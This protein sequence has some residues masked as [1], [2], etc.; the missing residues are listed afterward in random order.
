LRIHWVNQVLK[1]LE[2]LWIS[3]LKTRGFNFEKNNRG[4]INGSKAG[5]TITLTKQ[6]TGDFNCVASSVEERIAVRS[7]IYTKTPM[8]ARPPAVK[9]RLS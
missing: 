6:T 2:Q 3:K 1:G 7:Q 5:N 4:F 9:L 8:G